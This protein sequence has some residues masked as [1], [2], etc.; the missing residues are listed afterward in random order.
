M[1]KFVVF[2]G[3]AVVALAS[4]SKTESVLNNPQQTG[5]AIT[6]QP[7]AAVQTKSTLINKYVEGTGSFNVY[8]WYQATATSTNFDPSKDYT[9]YMNNV[10][11]KYDPEAGDI[12]KGENAQGVNTW[13]PANIYYWPKNGNLTFSAYYPTT[14]S[15]KVE[16][17]AANGIK[18]SDYTVSNPSDQIDVMFSD[19]AYDRYSTTQTDLVKEYD[20]VDIVFNHALSAA[21]FTVKTANDY[22]ADAIKLRKIEVVNAKTT[23]TFSEN[24]NNGRNDDTHKPEWTWADN[25]TNYTIYSVEGAGETVTTAGWQAGADCIFLPQNFSNDIAIKV[26]YA[27]KYIDGNEP[28]Y[29]EQTAEFP[30]KATTTGVD[31]MTAITAWEMGKWYKYTFTFTL[32]EIYFAP[33]VKDW[34]VVEVNPIEVKEN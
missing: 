17:T 26:T 14:I 22:V 25:T 4:C 29:L 19:R 5:S 28:K 8:A 6:F 27:I 33:S 13:K 30:L 15:D 32:N 21:S 20:G 2:A 9:L 23:G 24:C 12:D 10:T 11:C 31:P 18:I 34:D 3:I 7:L 16:V 1:K